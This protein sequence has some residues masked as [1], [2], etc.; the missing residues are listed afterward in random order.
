[1]ISL[2]LSN[3]SD[4]KDQQYMIWLYEEYHPLMFAVA[5]R[6]NK[7]LTAQEDVVQDSLIKLMKKVSRLR[8]FEP[9]ALAAYIAVTVRNTSINELKRADNRQFYC[10]C[11]ES[12]HTYHADSD[13]LICSL[14]K[15][16]TLARIW[17][18]LSDE[19]RF[20]F[21]G[22]H[23]MGYSDKEMA[24]VIKCKPDSIRT[25]LTRARRHAKELMEELEDN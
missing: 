1:M 12:F 11:P 14:L 6:Y 15:K 10:D 24:K 8:D 16:H 25:K 22:K 5:G 17:K 13:D 2:I 21:S 4:P 20:L 18:K 7:N 9:Y 23:L 3:L 19:E